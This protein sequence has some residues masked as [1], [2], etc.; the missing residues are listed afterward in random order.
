MAGT[1]PTILVV[2]D[3]RNERVVIA[4]VLGDAGFTV[5]AA[6]HDRGARAALRREQ[7][8]A[9]AVVA[10]R[11]EPRLAF[12]RYLRRRHPGLRALIVI[13]PTATRLADTD[14]DV[15]VTRPFDPRRLLGRVFELVLR[16]DDGARPHP[17]HRNAAEL[18]IGAAKLACLDSRRSAAAA[19]GARALARDLARQIGDT[20]ALQRGLAGAIVSRG[21]AAVR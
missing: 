12:M 21:P 4:A 2:G 19:A 14:D 20:R 17:S 6:V 13:E 10:L 11:E 18:G 7:R 5:M 16:Q 1:R 15:V 8:F 3:D 9:A